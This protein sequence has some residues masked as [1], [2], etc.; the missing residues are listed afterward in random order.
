M[1]IDEPWLKS[2]EAPYAVGDIV[3]CERAD[4][5]NWGYCPMHRGGVLGYAPTLEKALELRRH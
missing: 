1:E 3:D 5:G 4:A 2:K